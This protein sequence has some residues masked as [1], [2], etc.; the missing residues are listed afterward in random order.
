[1]I[2][3]EKAGKINTR[4][5]VDIVLRVSVERKINHIV[6]PSASGWTASLFKGVDK[7]LVCVTHAYGFA[8]KG[9]NEMSEE[10]RKE[11]T[12]SGIKVLTTTHVLS[13]AERGLS[14]KFGGI[15]PVEIVANTLRMFGQG[16][17]VATEIAIMAL[18]A[19]LI[20]YGEKIISL[21]G[22]EEGVDTA[23]IVIPS[24]AATILETKIIEILCKPVD[25]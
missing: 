11:L 7:N 3:F 19:G 1:M 12:D 10:K 16:V 13:G 25:F 9:K 18:D 6:F 22:T 17:K 21:G 5:V 14:R 2:G 24:H 8:E 4:N 23:I 15:Y 20:P